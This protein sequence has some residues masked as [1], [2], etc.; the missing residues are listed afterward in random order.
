M[1]GALIVRAPPKVN[2]HNHLYDIDQHTILIS[3]WTHELGIDKFLSHHHAGGDNKPPNL[4]INGLG[5]FIVDRNGNNVSAIMPV[6]TFIVKPVMFEHAE[7]DTIPNKDF[8][9][10]YAKLRNSIASKI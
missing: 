8:L 9:Q 7:K 5:R 4:L 2:W 6:A 10:I 3:D 1:F